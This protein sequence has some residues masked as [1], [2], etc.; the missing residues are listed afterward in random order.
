MTAPRPDAAPPLEVYLHRLSPVP[1]VATGLV[2]AALLVAA[3]VSLA[4]ATGDEIFERG[5]AGVQIST[6]A[7]AAFVT[8]LILAAA[9]TMPVRAL[10]QWQQALP[11]LEQTL[12][13]EGID[14]AKRL[15][16]GPLRRRL[17]RTVMAGGIGAIGGL[18]FNAWLMHN[19][20]LDVTGYVQSTGLWF[21]VVQPV[22]FGLGVRA[23]V[24]LG[25]DD[26]DI[27]DLVRGHL[28][29]DLANLDQLEVYGRLAL[30]GA[31]SWLVMAAIILLFFV[32]AAPVLVSVG[33]LVLALLAGAYAFASTIG[34]VV[35]ITSAAKATALAQLRTRLVQA[36]ESAV[37]GKKP[38][39]PVSE[40]VAYEAWLDARP[41]WPISAPVSRRLA[42]Y[43]LIPVIAWFGA[44]AAERVLEGVAG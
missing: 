31:L 4:L 3:Y 18:A 21:L 42:L 6:A 37:S 33:A 8:S 39:T 16:I 35:Q 17:G 7:W 14:K 38:D 13:E 25:D 36:G 44:A 30:R 40:L 23:A 9:L 26:R 43:G 32:F 28:Q 29:V 11:D 24:Q 2:I 5:D 19:S 1:P 22:L 10:A 41:I 15:A 27:A 20:G 34:P 12:D